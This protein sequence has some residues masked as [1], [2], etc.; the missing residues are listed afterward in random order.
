MRAFTPRAVLAAAL[1]VTL[2]GFA[3]Q[4]AMANL[5]TMNVFDSGWYDSTGLHDATNKNYIAG[6]ASPNNYNDYF[7]FDLSSV[8]AQIL[9]AEITL[10]MPTTNSDGGDGYAGPP[11]VF[12]LYSVNAPVSAV[13]QNQSGLAGQVIY[14]DLGSG[15]VLG[16]TGVSTADNGKLLT[17][18]LNSDGLALL[19]SGLGG[20]VVFGGSL[21]LVGS[22]DNYTFGW[23]GDLSS[24]QIT[25]ATVPEPVMFIQVGVGM[26]AL[27][28][29]ARRRSRLKALQQSA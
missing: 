1:A 19:N 24:R 7:V 17:I 22:G 27:L 3:P 5:I 18:N 12:S 8:Q 25:V 29:H 15:T 28:I 4:R 11:S 16:S 23:T 9:T 20:Q 14:A 26:T 13:M 2:V 6:F 21:A 10:Y